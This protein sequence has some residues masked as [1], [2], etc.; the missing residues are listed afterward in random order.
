MMILKNPH[1]E[2]KLTGWKSWAEGT[3]KFTLLVALKRYHH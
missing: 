2:L 1:C 3:I